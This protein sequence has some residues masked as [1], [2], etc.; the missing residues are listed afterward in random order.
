[1]IKESIREIIVSDACHRLQEEIA[2][3]RLVVAA[4]TSERD[5]LRYNICPELAARYADRIGNYENRLHYQEIMVRELKRR[6]EI[7]QVALNREREISQAEVDQQVEAE[8][9]NYRDKVDEEK[10]QYQQAQREQKE[11]EARKRAYRKKW[12]KQHEKQDANG[13]SED[14]KATGQSATDNERN[15]STDRTDRTQNWQDH[16]DEDIFGDEDSQGRNDSVD[17]DTADS[18]VPDVKEMYRKIVRRLHPDANPNITERE[19]ELFYKAVQAYKDG[20]IVTLQEIYDEVFG[21]GE[22][23]SVEK[24]LSYDELVELR[25][26]LLMKVEILNVEIDSI[27]TSFPYNAKDILNNQELV[28]QIRLTLEQQIGQNEE[29]IRQLN[30]RLQQLTEEMKYKV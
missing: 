29:T 18:V 25:D 12:E 21:D 2:E 23:D 22:A 1:M 24:E 13:V 9:Q 6:I 17:A 8:Y 26:R 11:R 16:T 19:K 27:K 15:N 10:H 20:D 28:E 5:D 14:P 4:L 7:V 30:Q 3:L